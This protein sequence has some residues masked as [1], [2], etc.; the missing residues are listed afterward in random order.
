MCEK[1]ER[2]LVYLESEILIV[3]LRHDVRRRPVQRAQVRHGKAVVP[4]R[5]LGAVGQVQDKGGVIGRACVGGLVR[6]C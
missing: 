3:L 4:G 6:E 2:T 1:D 5:I